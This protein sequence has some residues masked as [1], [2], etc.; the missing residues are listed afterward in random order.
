MGA[1]TALVMLGLRYDTD[2][3]RGMGA[4]IAEA[5]RD[6]AYAASIELAQEKG[7]FPLLD[8]DRYLAPPRFASRLPGA[9][10]AAIR[11]HGLRNSHLLSIAPT[12]TISLAFAANASG[13]IEPTFS[14]TYVRK[15]RE[16]KGIQLNEFARQLEISPAYW[17]R[18]EREMAK[19][20]KKRGYIRHEPVGVIGMIT[21]WNWPL[22]QI[23]CKVAPALA[24][25][26]TMVLKPSE[27]APFS[28][29]VWAEVLH[30][31]GHEIVAE[32][33][34]VLQRDLGHHARQR[35]DHVGAVEPAA[36]PH[37][38][39]RDLHSPRGAALSKRWHGPERSSGSLQVLHVAAG[40]V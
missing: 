26:C 12:G 1:L 40:A 25:G 37:F 19:F 13:G 20:P 36:Q 39:H 21:P 22:N 27:I 2:E 18:I 17:S 15:K 14:W 32:V 28:A 3:A 8:A 24:T 10:Q 9:L 30:A 6:E 23:A 16:E 4:K 34:G 35:G 5:M 7:A 33:V 11:K 31:A 38:D 29:Q